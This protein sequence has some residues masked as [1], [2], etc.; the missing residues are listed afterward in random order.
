MRRFILAAG[1]LALF[2]AALSCSRP[3]S[4]G[5]S[6]VLVTLDTTRADHL[7]VYGSPGARTP[8][9]DRLARS[10]TLF[11]DAIVDV[12]VTLPSHTTILTG[13]PALGHGV[14]YNADFKVG[15]QAA[16]LAE[17]FTERGYDTA[18]IVSS[19]I[20]ESSFGLDQGFRVYDDELPPYAIFDRSKYPTTH[21]LP[22]AERRAKDVIDSSIAWLGVRKKDSYFLWAHLYDAHFPYDPP[23][24]WEKTSSSEYQTEIN[25]LDH[26]L[27][28]LLFAVDSEP[29]GEE[30]MIVVTADHGEGLDQHREENHG[31]FVYDDTIRVPLLARAKGVLSEGR[32]VPELARSVDLAPTILEATGAPSAKLGIGGSL[33]AVATGAGAP[34]DTA[35]YAESVKTKLFYSGSGLKALRTKDV[36]YILAPRPELYDLVRDPGETRNLLEGGSS[37][38][39]GGARRAELARR[40]RSLLS[41]EHAV[42]EA[43]N[44]DEETLE[45]IRSL[46]Y[47]AGSDGTAKP[48]TAE[49]EMTMTG[50]DPKDLV[51][52]S[53]GAREIQNGFYERG[54]KKLRRFFATATPPEKDPSLARLWAAAHLDYAKIWMVR[55]NY[56]EAAN[57]YARAL[58]VDPGYDD[59]AWSRVYALNLAGEPG[60]AE[61]AAAARLETNPRAWKVSFHRAFALAFLGRR[62]EARTELERITR[63]APRE[64]DASRGAAAFLRTLGTAEE[65]RTLETYRTSEKRIAEE[66][67]TKKR[68][69]D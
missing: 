47:V 6:V 20:V 33:V 51:D 37:P 62:E 15:P 24:P 14:R 18:A 27:G 58:Q 8:S 35:G 34:P 43:A 59:A 61:R 54:E 45:G 23:P 25:S 13:V 28:R 63:E 46:G 65:R 39:L 42:V 4:A 44:V 26:E 7:G 40:V 31:I 57:E 21:W 29:R 64:L 17:A 69:D 5:R 68:A 16:T 53:M 60:L 55:E 11:V 19:L 30:T 22:A 38:A 52:V 1:I 66:D 3:P 10:G 2:A 9:L 56:L 67:A 48:G 12:P 41:G 32:I 50:F 49:T 36:K